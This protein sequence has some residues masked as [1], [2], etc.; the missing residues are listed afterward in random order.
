MSRHFFNKTI[1]QNTIAAVCT[2]ALLFAVVVVVEAQTD[3]PLFEEE[4]VCSIQQG[5]VLYVAPANLQQALEQSL[6][7]T[8]QVETLGAL[9]S[10][11]PPAN[12]SNAV[13]FEGGYPAGNAA[14]SLNLL[15]YVTAMTVTPEI[16]G[17]LIAVI[18][19]L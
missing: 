11:V 18:R 19:S 3:E 17:A 16:P 5:P 2:I 12:Q 9:L 13:R 1:L 10:R 4:L 8:A 15:G 7:A 6:G 14:Q